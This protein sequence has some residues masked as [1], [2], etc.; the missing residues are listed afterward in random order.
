MVDRPT[1]GPFYPR[2][3]PC[4][5]YN[6]RGLKSRLCLKCGALGPHR[7]LYARSEVG[8]RTQWLQLFWAC[9]TCNSLNHVIVPCYR[10][11]FLP[12]SLPSS[13]AKAVVDTL[14]DH[15]L[16]F[17]ELLERLRRKGVEGVPHLF[18]SDLT[19]VLE[20]LKGSGIV[21][22]DVV[23]RTHRALGILRGTMGRSVHLGA[24]PADG[25]TR[26]VSLYFKRDQQLV[27]AGIFC[28]S[29]G[30]HRFDP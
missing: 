25:S 16:D 17:E 9:E 29:C 22:E 11:R 15:P 7:T 3:H 30:Y 10:V 21:T 20:F 1:C 27:R 24:C 19:M 28:V 2:P 5:M 14:Q 12:S 8:G 13:L 18:N 4:F 26:L 6:P 23:N